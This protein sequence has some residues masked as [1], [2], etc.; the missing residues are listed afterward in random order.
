M[1]HVK[2]ALKAQKKLPSPK[3]NLSWFVKMGLT[4][5]ANKDT[6]ETTIQFEKISLPSGK[7]IFFSPFMQ[8]VINEFIGVRNEILRTY[9]IPL[10][11]RFGFESDFLN[12]NKKADCK[13]TTCVL[14]E[15]F[16][17]EWIR[18]IEEKIA[19]FDVRRFRIDEESQN[20]IRQANS[21][22]ANPNTPLGAR[23]NSEARHSE[24]EVKILKSVRNRFEVLRNLLVLQINL[25]NHLET[26][27]DVYFTWY[28]KRIDFYWERSKKRFRELPARAPT[29]HELFLAIDEMEHLLGSYR[30][31]NDRLATAV[32]DDQRY[33]KEF[34]KFRKLAFIDRNE[35]EAMVDA[36]Q[37]EVDEKT[38]EFEQAKNESMRRET[39]LSNNGGVRPPKS[40][41]RSGGI[42]KI[43]LGV[44][45]MV[46]IAGIDWYTLWDMALELGYS[47]EISI[48]IPALFA[49]ISAG[50][51]FGLQTFSDVHFSR[52]LK[53]KVKRKNLIWLI[54]ALVGAIG[55]AFGFMFFRHNNTVQLDGI[56]GFM[57]FDLIQQLL[58]VAPFFT[59]IIGFII[60]LVCFD[61]TWWYYRLVKDEDD[62]IFEL[63]KQAEAAKERLKLARE[64][65]DA[66]EK[67]LA[68]LKGV[69]EGNPQEAKDEM[70]H[71]WV[72]VA[73]LK[74]SPPSDYDEFEHTCLEAIREREL[75]W[76]ENGYIN[77]L[78]RLYGAI[79]A[80]LGI[81][82][83][84]M[85]QLSDIDIV[86]HSIAT[87]D[88]TALI[89]AYNDSVRNNP[90][91]SQTLWDD[92]VYSEELRANFANTMK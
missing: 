34:D 77:S 57:D 51:A 75:N 12:C 40:E 76:I 19:E 61:S 63:A 21:V 72:N 1:P 52:N 71:F 35:L 81:Y 24:T 25:V 8:T 91:R 45:L 37:R 30:D 85:S 14:C 54:V 73:G 53:S 28:R 44:L 83:S 64:S 80:Q 10:D 38:S 41:S 23:V 66:S 2:A 46:V 42:I 60:S 79:Q 49:I 59:T 20:S 56:Y 78:S 43:T 86:K 29:T 50:C 13:K 67:K 68:Q 74:G 15:N 26:L 18:L 33:K 5:Q 89:D 27:L 9:R 32:K 90:N 88:L 16:F 11:C 58:T 84:K 6:E 48:G 31:I 70:I 62:E 87:L 39:D 65:L 69:R 22:L 3:K 92:K 17:G 7:E 47:P 55:T 36:A 4:S 82:I